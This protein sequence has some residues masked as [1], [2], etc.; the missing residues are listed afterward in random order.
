MKKIVLLLIVILSGLQ[1]MV[2]INLPAEIYSQNFNFAQ[3]SQTQIDEKDLVLLETAATIAKAAPKV[4]KIWKG[5]WNRNQAFILL[6]PKERALL[7]STV[8]PP[9]EYLPVKTTRIPKNLQARIYFHREYPLITGNGDTAY[10]VGDIYAPALEPQLAK[11]PGSK[12]YRRLNYLYH[13]WFHGFQ[14]RQF[15]KIPREPET[16][17]K[18]PAV[19]PTQISAPDFIPMAELERRILST[20]IDISSRKEAGEILRQYLAVR[21]TRNHHLPDVVAMERKMERTERSALLVGSEAAAIAVGADRKEIEL[22]IK[23]YLNDPLNS[24]PALP[25]TDAQLMRW[26]LYGTGG[27]IGFLLDR[28]KVK[29]WREKLQKG[30]AHLDEMLIE[31]VGFEEQDAPSLKEKAF[32]QFIL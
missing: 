19:N 25:E 30:S 7:F 29:N 26:R 21:W 1:P 10:Q 22:S 18:K 11:V 12:E 9:P 13:E 31:A 15:A 5:F 8:V 16:F 27:A 24:Y 32:R 4:S 20:A 3:D 2:A 14:N 17:F 23:K 6:R 28:L